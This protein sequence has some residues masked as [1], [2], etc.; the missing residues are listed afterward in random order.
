VT[1]QTRG[2]GRFR[3]GWDLAN[4]SGARVPAGLY[5]ARVSDG[6]STRVTRIAVLR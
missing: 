4:A 5:L 3:F 6:R 1:D 2:P